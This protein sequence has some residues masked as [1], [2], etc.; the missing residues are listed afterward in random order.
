MLGAAEKTHKCCLPL[1]VAS[2]Y[3]VARCSA[4][5]GVGGPALYGWASPE[6]EVMELLTGVSG[7]EPWVFC[8]LVCGGA[9][10]MFFSWA[11]CILRG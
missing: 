11:V 4:V 9:W 3:V 8:N 6:D 1:L 7:G 5:A 2:R 10:G